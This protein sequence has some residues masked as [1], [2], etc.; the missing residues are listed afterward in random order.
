MKT[1]IA[2]PCMD[3]VHTEFARSLLD[4][5]KPEGTR[6]CFK[7]D[8]LIYDSRNLL[9]ITAIENG[10]DRIL[11]LDSDMTFPPDTLE[12]LSADMDKGYDLVTAVYVKRH[13]PIQPVLYST[14]TAPTLDGSVIKNNVV[15]FDNVPDDAIIPIEGCGFGCVM[16]SVSFLKRLWDEHGPIFSPF[17]WAGED[18]S[19]CLRAKLSGG[20]MVCDT[21]IRCGH[22]GMLTYTTDMIR[23]NNH[24]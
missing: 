9:T 16:T 12:R 15:Q 6:A 20:R 23:R 4:L 5:R 11:W 1:M 13:F 18:I 3:M 24:G 22:I 8:S 19:F 2:I 17:P 7:Q 10:F 14:V 21:S